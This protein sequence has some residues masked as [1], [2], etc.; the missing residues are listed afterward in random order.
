MFEQH[1]LESQ[2]KVPEIFDETAPLIARID[3]CQK[4]GNDFKATLSGG[5]VF[6]YSWGTL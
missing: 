1:V 6:K 2:D 5:S 3:G 4:Y